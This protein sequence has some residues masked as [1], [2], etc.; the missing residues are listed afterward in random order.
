MRGCCFPHAA[1]QPFSFGLCR[2]GGPVARLLAEAEPVHDAG[3]GEAEGEGEPDAD[4]AAVE[5]KAE[6]VAGGQGDDEVG[7]EGVEQHGSDV[8]DAAQG[9]GEVDLQGVAK[10]IEQE[11]EDGLCH[12]EADGLAVGEPRADVVAQQEDGDAGEHQ[13]G[14]HDV[15]TV[16]GGAAHVLQIVLAVEIADSHSYGGTH[17][18]V[19][20]EAYL[21]NGHHNLVAG[22]LQAAEPAYHDGAEAERGGFH[23]HLSGDGPAQAV[24]LCEVAPVD[25]AGEESPAVDGIAAGEE[26][27][28][29]IGCHHEDARG[30]GGHSR[31]GDAHFGQAQAA[32]DEE[33]V[34][35]DVEHVA[36][37]E[38]PHGHLGVGDAVGELLEAVEPEHEGE[39][40]QEHEEVGADV[41]QQFFGLSHAVEVEVERAH[42]E[43]HEQGHEGVGGEAVAQ[44]LTGF[45]VASLPEEA[46][47]DGGEPVGEAGAED[48][49][50]VE[51]VVHEAG[52]CQFG[53]AVVAN[54][55][56]VGKA[57]DD[58]ADLSD[59]D[60]ESEREQGE[61]GPWEF[62][63]SFRVCAGWLWVFGMQ[64]YGKSLE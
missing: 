19:H 35:R 6:E 50:Q 39:R 60:G 40:G 27:E 5:H 32:V 26:E 3:A 58:D 9:V 34:A 44:G 13:Q 49:G 38:Y 29:K 10:L 57:E 42:D 59:D 21:R 62:H 18:V 64:N 17:A 14:E 22:Q 33:I 55:Q 30:E 63:V 45:G 24:E 56:R 12:H 31:A 28:G 7:D 36:R 16:A 4:D 48:D 11:G 25:A 51:H 23:A 53:G 54:H 47:H 61:V 1:S 20:H 52:S 8:G 2:Q 37:E 43:A 41:G 46:A 15:E